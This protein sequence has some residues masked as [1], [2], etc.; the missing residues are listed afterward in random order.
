MIMGGAYTS[1]DKEEILKSALTV[2]SFALALYTIVTVSVNRVYIGDLGLLKILPY[3]YWI[4]L[5]LIIP[6]LFFGEKSKTY[7]TMGL[8]LSIIYI[9]Y[10]PA[11]IK[12]NVW[13]SNSYYPYWEGLIISQTGHLVQS[14]YKIITSY[15]DWPIFL[16][17]TSALLLIP[18]LP[19]NFILKIFPVLFICF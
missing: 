16:Y 2:S 10:I 3:H 12:S 8:L 6:T 1:W 13:L 18:G 17:F 11:T 5:V 14:P 19:E 9:F 7:A 4:G 15:Q